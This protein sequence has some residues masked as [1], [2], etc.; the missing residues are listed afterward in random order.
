M[1]EDDDKVAQQ[2]RVGRHALVRCPQQAQRTALP[3]LEPLGLLQ[4]RDVQAPEGDQAQAHG[5]PGGARPCPW[6]TP[7]TPVEQQL[8]GRAHP[9]PAAG[10]ELPGVTQ[11]GPGLAQQLLAAAARVVARAQGAAAVLG[12]AGQRLLGPQPAVG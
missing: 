2:L 5:A 1:V 11:G 4:L 8:A 6:P 3:L 7:H 9:G 12:H 10:Q